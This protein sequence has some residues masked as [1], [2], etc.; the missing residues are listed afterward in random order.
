MSFVLVSRVRPGAVPE[1]RL[2]AVRPPHGLQLRHRR[3]AGVRLQR[4]VPP[5]GGE[6]DRVPGR[7]PSHVE[8]PSA[9]VCGYVVN[10][11][12]LF[13]SCLCMRGADG[14]FSEFIVE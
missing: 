11:F 5:A 4:G 13:L 8:R 6:A 7:W 12:F 2:A 1:P 10:A 9:K 3:L 14:V